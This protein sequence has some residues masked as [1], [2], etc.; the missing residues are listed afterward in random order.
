MAIIM[1][2]D[3]GFGNNKYM[4]VYKGEEFKNS[5]ESRYIEGEGLSGTCLKL[6]DKYYT[7]GE[8]KLA[9]DYEHTTKDHEIHRLLLWRAMYEVYKKTN[10]KD[11]YI[12]VS[13]GMDSWKEDRGKKVL[14]FMSEIKT[15]TVEDERNKCKV[16]LNIK[17]IDC[18]PETLSGLPAAKNEIN[19]KEEEEVLAFDI[20]T[21]NFQIVKYESGRA[22][23]DRSFSTE[24]GMNRIYE[25]LAD[26]TKNV[27]T[28]KIKSPHSVKVY[29]KKTSSD[30]ISVIPE[31]EDVILDYLNN[32]IFDEVDKRINHLDISDFTK[33]C[34]LGGGSNYL[35]RF[36]SAKY[37]ENNSV[38]INDAYYMTS[39]GLLK[40]AIMLYKD[41]IRGGLNEK[42]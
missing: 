10:E 11:F 34:F 38:F 22:L 25:D 32:I 40:R 15:I 17:E 37:I 1:S 5:F 4:Y 7:F 31:I 2:N 18:S 36:L 20:G 42:E 30:E 3:Y 29:L 13:C 8:G 9:S 14:E 35:K 27:K 16:K 28:V 12:M 24:F 6:N 19:V 39:K 21:K 26:R 23:V 33:F 41:K